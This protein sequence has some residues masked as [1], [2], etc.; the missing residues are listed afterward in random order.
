[1]QRSSEEQDTAAEIVRLTH[2]WMEAA[3]A[4]DAE[5]L[6]QLMATEYRL[7][8]MTPSS[9]YHAVV[10]RAA[11]IAETLRRTIH[12][13]AYTDSHVRVD[14]DVAV[15][16]ARSTSTAT[17]AQDD[18]AAPAGATRTLQPHLTDIWVRREGR[19]QVVLRHSIRL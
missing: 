18:G 10:D 14:G 3:Q 11:W 12:D 6:E 17:I 5:T 15:M 19:W 16:T 4:H 2:R 8:I 9:G 7:V 1:M 13:F